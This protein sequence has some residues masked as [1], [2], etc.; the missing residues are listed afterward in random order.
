MDTLQIVA[1]VYVG[2]PN[3][4]V[5]FSAEGLIVCGGHGAKRFVFF[6]PAIVA[7]DVE[8]HIEMISRAWDISSSSVGG[9][10]RQV[11]DPVTDEHDRVLK[12]SEKDAED[13]EAL[14]AFHEANVAASKKKVVEIAAALSNSASRV[15]QLA[16]TRVENEK[17]ALA[18]VK[19]QVSKATKMV[20][21][22]EA[23]LKFAKNEAAAAG[24]LEAV[25]VK[26]V[27]TAS[28]EVK[29]WIA[30]SVCW[31]KLSLFPYRKM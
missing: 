11:S 22:A 24:E 3:C 12:G 7:D 30:K 16:V 21:S 29:K 1:R 13:V 6:S 28:T 31:H 9:E 18:I 25:G 27:E 10:S 23:Q 5:T 15:S 2:F 4:T 20:A 14:S 17:E 19:A 26:K 8:A